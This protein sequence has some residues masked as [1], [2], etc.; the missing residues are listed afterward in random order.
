MKNKYYVI[1]LILFIVI[2]INL[3]IKNKKLNNNYSMLYSYVQSNSLLEEN[4]LINYKKNG[5]KIDLLSIVNCDTDK[6]KA[7]PFSLVMYYPDDVCNVCQENLFD[8]MQKYTNKD[9]YKNLVVM[10]PALSYNDFASINEQYNLN[11]QHVYAFSNG[12]FQN[13]KIL[14]ECFFILDKNMFVRDIYIFG[15]SVNNKQLDSY[16]NIVINKYNL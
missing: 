9:F 11:I 1:L 4:L 12:L 6:F 5:A 15:K 10:L 16:L 13:R 2:N 7:L 3:I 8:A 14:K